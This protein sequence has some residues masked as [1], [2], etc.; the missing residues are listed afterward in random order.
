M[1]ATYRIVTPM[2]CGGADPNRSAEVRLP[3]FKGVLRFWWRA[4]AWGRLGGGLNERELE[5]IRKREA[6]LF[7]SADG[8]QSRVL[9]RLGGVPKPT[10]VRAGSVLGRDGKEVPSGTSHTDR[11]GRGARYLGYGVMGAFGQRAGKLGRPC[12]VAPFEFTVQMRCRG[13]DCE[14]MES[15]KRTLIALGTFGGMGAKSRKGYGSLVLRSLRID[16]KSDWRAPQTIDELGERIRG[17]HAT[18][19]RRG[20]ETRAADIPFTALSPRA[21]HVLLSANRQKPLELLDLV[22]REVV[23]FRAWGHRGKIL[24]NVPSERNFERDHD[25]MKLSHWQRQQHPERI[26]FG[27]P[28]DYGKQK[29]QQVGPADGKLDRRASPL[30]IHI[31]LVGDKPVAVLSLVPARFLPRPKSSPPGAMPQISVG[32]S[33]IS[34]L[35][36]RELFQPVHEFLNRLTG[37]GVHRGKSRQEPFTDA[38]EVQIE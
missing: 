34:Q 2:F 31:H 23:R 5:K 12:V 11:V 20:A 32:G 36:E 29:D 37:S 15:L 25:L 27:L 3:S 18:A 17:L 1:D 8:G 9:M 19:T 35:P 13:L 26:A 22:G 24:G 10:V 16:R 7:G 30:F 38:R 28:H 21:R 6:T 14:V 4:L 33:K